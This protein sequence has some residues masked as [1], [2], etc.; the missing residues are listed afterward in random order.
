MA[1][2]RG[3]VYLG[4]EEESI[5]EKNQMLLNYTVNKIGG[6]P[7]WPPL[8]NFKFVSKCPLCGLHRMLVVQCYAPLENSAYHRTLYVF[9]CIN[10]NCWIQSESWSCVRSQIQDMGTTKQNTTVTMPSSNTNMTWCKGSDE[11]DEND[12][13]DT[14]NGNVMNIDNDPANSCMRN[15][16]EDDESNSYELETVEQA[17]G[18]LQV[19]DAHNANMSP[20]GAVGANC[21]PEAA[22]ELEG[23][24]E[25]GLVI[26]E[27]PTGPSN[28]IEAL[29]H[30]TAELPIDLRNRLVWAPLQ[31][32]PKYIYVEEEYKKT[33]VDD[34]VTELLNKYKNEND[35]EIGGAADKAGGGGL[36]EEIYEEATPLHGDR[37][38][39]AF[40]TRLR[41]NPGQILRYTREEP[42][43]LG[44]PLP[45]NSGTPESP[46]MPN[47]CNRCGSRLI[48][49]LQLVPE[50]GDTLKILP[51]NI[52]LSHLHFLSVLI[53]TCSQSCWQNTDTVVSET[54]VFQ[55]EIV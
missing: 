16:D 27:T 3:K 15:S 40:I 9:A 37:L 13:G 21:G 4:Y 24:D 26:A 41:N 14:T 51:N 11:W 52:S 50:L 53:F 44:A 31:F 20:Q 48:C 32:V 7:N 8:D 25:P 43:L 46:S 12:N 22:A 39:H 34:R 29:L 47:V 19:F 35:I 28:D 38:F 18:N 1:K 55:P 5:G 23:G 33:C 30:Q 17:L 54:V 6:F 2:L 36:D 42:P 10:P 49:E 45:V